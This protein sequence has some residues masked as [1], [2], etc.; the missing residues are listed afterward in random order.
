[1]SHSFANGKNLFLMRLILS[2]N[3]VHPLS[4]PG[5]IYFLQISAERYIEKMAVYLSWESPFIFVFLISFHQKEAIPYLFSESFSD[6][7]R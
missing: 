7:Y 2:G 5:R 1:M 3:R 4:K 6:E